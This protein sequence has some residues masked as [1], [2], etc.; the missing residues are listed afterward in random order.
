MRTTH[1]YLTHVM[2]AIGALILAMAMRGVGTPVPA[3]VTDGDLLQAGVVVDDGV[4][5]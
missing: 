5:F 4:P 1:G 3:P 2:I